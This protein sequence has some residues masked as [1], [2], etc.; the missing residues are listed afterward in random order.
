M[1]AYGQ[2]NRGQLWVQKVSALPTW[3]SADIG[4]VLLLTTSGDLYYASN[5]A[6]VKVGGAGFESGVKMY[7]YQNSAPVG[8]VIDATVTDALIGVK[9]GT[10]SYNIAGGNVA[11]TWTQPSHSHSGGAVDSHVLTVAELPPHEHGSQYD[12][13]TPGSIDT[14][15]GGSE[16]AGTPSGQ[17]FPYWTYPTTQT[18]GGLGHTHT[19]SSIGTGATADTWRPKTAVGIIATKS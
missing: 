11:G 6:W 19:L 3:S 1:D 17:F 9:G 14:V 7:F 16:I 4:R 15:G 5:I 12:Q 10:S 13:R 8:W 18:G 2:N